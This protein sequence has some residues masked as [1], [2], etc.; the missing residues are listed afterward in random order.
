MDLERLV[1]GIAQANV[2]GGVKNYWVF[3]YNVF[4]GVFFLQPFFDAPVELDE[5]EQMQIAQLKALISSQVVLLQWAVYEHRNRA[6]DLH[7]LL[8][9]S[10]GCA[11]FVV[12]VSQ[13]QRISANTELWLR[14]SWAR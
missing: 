9:Q 2:M 4:L 7:D 1:M 10:Y 13:L 6:S 8:I 12:V 3:C 14:I 11:F 5:Y